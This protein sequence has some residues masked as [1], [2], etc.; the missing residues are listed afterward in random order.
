MPKMKTKKAVA[1][2]I[3]KTGTGKLKCHKAYKGKSAKAERE[4]S[5]RTLLS[6]G[7]AKRIESL[8]TYK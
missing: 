5:K 2:R 8:I 6:K 3:T 1:K 7:D 4:M